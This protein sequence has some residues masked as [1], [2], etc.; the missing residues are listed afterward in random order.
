[1]VRDQGRRHLHALP[2]VVL[3]AHPVGTFVNYTTNDG[4]ELV[5]PKPLDDDE[6]Q[7]TLSELAEARNPSASWLQP[8]YPSRDLQ[9]TR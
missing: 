6:V 1:V 7:K 4:A 2:D 3:E 8:N 5:V 9:K